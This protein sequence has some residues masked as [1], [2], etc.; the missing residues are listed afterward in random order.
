MFKKKKKKKKIPML[1][2]KYAHRLWSYEAFS[3]KEQS[4]VWEDLEKTGGAGIFNRLILSSEH[5][6]G[7]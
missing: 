6:L 1:V 4:E 5:N 3:E 2:K 7:S